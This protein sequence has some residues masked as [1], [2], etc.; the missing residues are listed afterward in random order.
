MSFEAAM[1]S[2]GV[3]LA[4]LIAIVT[5]VLRRFNKQ[6]FSL[7]FAIAHFIF[8][9]IMSAIY[10]PGEKD[11]QHQLFWILPAMFDLP[12]SFIYPLLAFGN[13]VVLAIVFA[14]LGTV[15]YALIGWCIDLIISKNRKELFP[16]K[17][18]VIPLL[19]FLFFVGILAFK[20]YTYIRLPDDKKAKIELENAKDER[21]RFY[22]LNDAA[23]KSFEAKDYTKAEQYARELLNLSEKYPKDWN[24]GNAVY[25]S[26]M[27]LGRLALVNNDM[28]LAK[29]HLFLSASTPGSPQ[30]DTFGPN[31]SLAKDML[32]KGQR[33]SV[34]E[35]LN[36]CKRFWMHQERV[37]DWVREINEG[38]VPDFGANLLY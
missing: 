9:L 1:L 30:L 11:A 26:H 8:I 21:T 28:Q 20:N 34:I 16:T 14:T 24:Y 31:L 27:V 15:Q 23:K 38:K 36:K 10:F 35:F 33:D 37:D 6:K 3:G 29:E 22:A 13:M 19:V 25:D 32:E 17:R 2:A 7:A 5:Y 12:L 4:V 18:F